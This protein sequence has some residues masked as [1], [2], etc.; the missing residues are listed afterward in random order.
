MKPVVIDQDHLVSLKSEISSVI[1][2][3]LDRRTSVF[4][5]PTLDIRKARYD[6]VRFSKKYLDLFTLIILTWY[7]EEYFQGFS[8]YIRYEIEQYLNQQLKFPE[9]NA[10]LVSKSVLD[11][12]IVAFCF[13]NSERVLF[14]TLLDQKRIN[15]VLDQVHLRIAKQPRVRKPVYR[16]GYKDKGSLRPESRWLPKDDWSFREEQIF[17]EEKRAEYQRIVTQIVRIS[18]GGVLRRQLFRKED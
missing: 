1:K 17:L 7:A 3:R 6:G 12:V 10:S 5:N 2:K 15:R 13:E 8:G 11:F 14:G 16:R 18:G 4:V 9:L